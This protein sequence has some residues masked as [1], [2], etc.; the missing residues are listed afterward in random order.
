MLT[1]RQRSFCGPMTFS[2]VVRQL[3]KI[4]GRD[5]VLERAEDL[6][7]YEYDAG[8][9]TGSPRAVV[10]VQTTE[11]G[12]RVMR[13]ASESGFPSGPRRA[14]TGLSGRAIAR[15]GAIVLALARMNRILENDVEK[16]RSG[17]E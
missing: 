12:S 4:V 6:M 5:A 14:G 17:V 10:F 13:L 7:L 11:Q 2:S 8:I 15:I 9:L 3:K 1:L 16:Q